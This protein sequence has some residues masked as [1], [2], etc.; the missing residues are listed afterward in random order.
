MSRKLRP[1]VEIVSDIGAL[2]FALQ[3]HSAAD[4][5]SA[6]H[7]VRIINPEMFDWL[8]ELLAPS[9]HVAEVARTEPEAA[10]PSGKEPQP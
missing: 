8:A 10:P 7:F 1:A 3:H 9:P 4:I 5:A 2:G 6:V